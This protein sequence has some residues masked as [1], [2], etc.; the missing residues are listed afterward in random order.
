MLE[1][2]Y[3][4]LVAHSL[5]QFNVHVVFRLFSV[6]HSFLTV[7]WNFRQHNTMFRIP[8]YQLLPLHKK[9]TYLLSWPS[10]FLLVGPL[11]KKRWWWRSAVCEK[12][13]AR[14]LCVRICEEDAGKGEEPWGVSA[15]YL[16]CWKPPSSSVERS[17][18]AL[19]IECNFFVVQK[20][21]ECKWVRKKTTSPPL[22]G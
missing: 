1:S 10:Q 3:N 20:I 8:S 19:Q 16:H 2:H 11:S 9:S 7:K 18:I 21:T 14:K 6:N 22:H 13:A 17:E 15:Y 5:L 4:M 12:S